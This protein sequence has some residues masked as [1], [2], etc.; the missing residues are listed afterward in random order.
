[1]VAKA[2]IF[3]FVAAFLEHSLSFCG[4]VRGAFAE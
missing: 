2:L 1:M 3:V 4:G